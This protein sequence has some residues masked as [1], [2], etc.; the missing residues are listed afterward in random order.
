MSLTIKVTGNMNTP[1]VN[2]SP[3]KPRSK[4]LPARML[5]S[6]RAPANTPDKRASSVDLS[7]L[8][9]IASSYLLI[10]DRNSCRVFRLSLNTP[11]NFVV[12][13]LASEHFTPRQAIQP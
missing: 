12:I 8:F 11:V 10:I 5:E 2:V 13:V 9:F 1:A 3:Q 7:S 6:T 4:T